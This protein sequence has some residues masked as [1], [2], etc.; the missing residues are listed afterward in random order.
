VLEQCFASFFILFSDCLRSSSLFPSMKTPCRSCPD[1]ARA[2]LK[3]H[4]SSFRLSSCSQTKTVRQ[5]TR[6]TDL[7]L[8]KERK[9]ERR[10][11]PLQLVRSSRRRLSQN[12]RHS[13]R[14]RRL[15]RLSSPLLVQKDHRRCERLSEK[16]S[17]HPR[18]RPAL[19]LQCRHL[20]NRREYRGTNYA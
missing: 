3:M 17:L 4:V 6:T 15:R 7:H 16:E 1:S 9:S 19:L 14:A 5:R 10:S 8:K 11:S 2:G 18:L 20:I 12:R 13:S